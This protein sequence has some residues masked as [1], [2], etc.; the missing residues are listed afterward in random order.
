MNTRRQLVIVLGAG[1]L[2]P[3]GLFAQAPAKV[4]RVGFH[5]QGHVDFVD[6]HFIYGPF[7]QGM[8]EIGYVA[9]KN[10]LIEWRSAEGKSERLPE[11]AADLVRLKVDVLATQCQ[12]MEEA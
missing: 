6:S 10:L 9:G 5:A 7:T 4:W 1:V 3:L 8:R 12:P 2:A 11:L